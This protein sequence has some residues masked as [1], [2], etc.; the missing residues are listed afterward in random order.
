MTD[1]SDGRAESI[2]DLGT[3]TLRSFREGDVHVVVCGGELD[4]SGLRLV[5]RELRRV[6]AGDAG[7]IVLDLAALDFIDSGGVRLVVLADRRQHDRLVVVRGRPGVQRVFELC[8]VVRAL[9]FVD[10]LPEATG[11]AESRNGRS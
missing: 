8:G 11:A 5:E 7:V 1:V 9:T 6:E 4:L 3:L 2:R 10:A